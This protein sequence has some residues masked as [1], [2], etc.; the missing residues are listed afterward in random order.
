MNHQPNRR[1]F[2]GAAAVAGAAW[3]LPG[4]L[5]PAAGAEAEALVR[6]GL[7]HLR[8][9]ALKDAIASFTRA[10]QLDPTDV[11]ALDLRSAVSEALGDH[12]GAMADRSDIIRLNPSSHNFLMRAIYAMGHDSAQSI[13]DFTEVIRQKSNHA[14]AYGFRA[15]V[16]EGV[17][18]YSRSLLDYTVYARLDP[19]NADDVAEDIA[20]VRRLLR[21]G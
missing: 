5:K 9:G 15:I 7:D 1:R 13:A 8:R 10:I 16:F 6:R 14:D 17:G 20:R 4:M 2:L 12:Y 18:E 11:Q 19:E 3:T 21:K